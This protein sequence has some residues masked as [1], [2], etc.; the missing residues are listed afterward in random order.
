MSDS[1]V[2]FLFTQVK[3]AKNSTQYRRA[4]YATERY[5][6]YFLTRRTVC[7]DIAEEA[8][9]VESSGEG[10]F[11]RFFFPLWLV[12]RVL[13]LEREHSVE[14]VHTNFSPQPLLAGYL[15][16]HFG[17]VWVADIY[18]SPHISLDLEVAPGHPGRIGAYL[19]NRTLVMLVERTLSAADLLVVAMV[20]DVLERYG[21]HPDDENVVRV[22]NGV[23]LD[24]TRKA[25]SS[26]KSDQFTLVYVGPV[27]KV[28][29]LNTVF[30]A[31]REVD[32]SVRNVELRLVGEVNDESWMSRAIPDLENVKISVF[33]YVPHDEA[34]AEIERS[35]VGLCPLSL[36]IENYSAAYPI[37]VF[38]YMALGKPTIATWTKGTETVLSDGETG[39]L[40]P[41]DD[42]E[43]MADAILALY[44]NPDLRARLGANASEAVERYDW[45]RINHRVWRRIDALVGQARS[46]PDVASSRRSVS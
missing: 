45:D 31:L 20:P 16:Q 25:R 9:S 39:L 40:V 7:D 8:F 12:W 1:V 21:V 13:L 36:T 41:P 42:G 29:G 14:Y 34:L 5:D 18:D 27:R 2:V 22:T 23:A 43:A 35:T 15:L 6:V 11:Y 3:C 10:I 33:G 32:S 38:E 17:H 46:Q 28:R 19:Y 37:K 4:Q 26:P 44:D 24:E 30:D